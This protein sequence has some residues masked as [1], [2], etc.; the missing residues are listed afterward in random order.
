MNAW[1]VSMLPLLTLLAL[2]V[3][4]LS[5][6]AVLAVLPLAVLLG[7]IA[8]PLIERLHAA[9]DIPRLLGRL[10][11]GVL[12]VGVAERRGRLADLVL[13]LLEV[14]L[15]IVLDRLRVVAP[16]ALQGVAGVADLL[17]HPLVGDAAGRFIQ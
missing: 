3:L 1:S 6:L 7:A 10:A 16:L 15:Q 17:A 4:L 2:L 9:H 13:Q 5:L 11:D 14:R 8:H 12:L